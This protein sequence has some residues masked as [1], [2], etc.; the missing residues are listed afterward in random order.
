MGHSSGVQGWRSKRILGINVVP[1]CVAALVL[2]SA[3]LLAWVA[4]MTPRGALR[5]GA[6]TAM[7]LVQLEQLDP[8]LVSASF[9]LEQDGIPVAVDDAALTLELLPFD[10]K[11]ALGEVARVETRIGRSH[12]LLDPEKRTRFA[13]E[14]PCNLRGRLPVGIRIVE[15]R[16][17]VQIAGRDPIR[18]GARFFAL[19]SELADA[20]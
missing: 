12:F 14:F 6:P 19:R 13:A 20:R 16:L 5:F 10:G 8:G 7:T 18:G 9:F 11:Q 1:W 17:T 2:P 3:M 4:R 15:G